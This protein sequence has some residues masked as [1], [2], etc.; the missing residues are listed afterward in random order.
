VRKTAYGVLVMLFGVM[1]TGLAFAQAKVV[2]VKENKQVGQI[3]FIEYRTM[4][5][6]T[7]KN[8]GNRDA[9]NV[10][11]GAKC[12]NCVKTAR[13]LWELTGKTATIKYLAAGD[14]EEA[15]LFACLGYFASSLGV[16]DPALSATVTCKH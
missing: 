13:G 14:K 15:D 4:L 8:V 5:K 16:Y 1:L 9:E 2:V 10:V 11:I 6:V 3:D 7:V 12:D